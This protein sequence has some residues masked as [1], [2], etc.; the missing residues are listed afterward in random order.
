MNL[1]LALWEFIKGG[2][3]HVRLFATV[4]LNLFNKKEYNM[5]YLKKIA[6]TNSYSDNSFAI[7]KTLVVACYIEPKAQVTSANAAVSYYGDVDVTTS[8]LEA[9]KTTDGTV[10]VCTITENDDGT[11]VDIKPATTLDATTKYL[12]RGY[13]TLK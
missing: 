9:V 10:S 5:S 8:Y 11:G 2:C 12:I 13:V 7:N 1:G 4:V 3:Y 6:V